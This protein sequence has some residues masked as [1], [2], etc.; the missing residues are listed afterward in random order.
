MANKKAPQDQNCLPEN[1]ERR[2]DAESKP[3]NNKQ[4]NLI[5]SLNAS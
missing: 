3:N 2:R 5:A 1:H 4:Q